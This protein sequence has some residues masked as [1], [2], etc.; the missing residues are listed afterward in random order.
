VL[1]RRR[2]EALRERSGGRAAERPEQGI[3]RGL[4]GL[5]GM[6][7]LRAVPRIAL[8]LVGESRERER[9]DEVLAH[10]VGDGLADA[11][12]VARGGHRDD[13]DGRGS[14]RVQDAEHVQALDVG[15]VEVEQHEV[16]GAAGQQ[17]ERLGRAMRDAGQREAGHALDV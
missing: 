6:L 11:L 7:D 9:L 14:A 12:R 4:I 10:P 3:D 1:E 2:V 5:G 15:Q 16:D 8:E 17:L 13:V